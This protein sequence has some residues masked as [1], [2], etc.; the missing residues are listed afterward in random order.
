[1]SS[2][3]PEHRGPDLLGKSLGDLGEHRGGHLEDDGSAEGLAVGLGHQEREVPTHVDALADREAALGQVVV[4]D[5]HDLQE[6]R[7][8]GPVLS[9]VLIIHD[10]PPRHGSPR[11]SL[12]PPWCLLCASALFHGPADHASPGHP[13]QGMPGLEERR[14]LTVQDA[15]ED[16]QRRAPG[17]EP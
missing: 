3:R 16:L 5:Q 12:A 9:L 14:I 10:C 15:I 4:D 11:A 6:S 13:A 8:R 2:A 7:T 17:Q 1:V